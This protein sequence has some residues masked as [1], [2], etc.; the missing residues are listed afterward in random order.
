MRRLLSAALAGLLLAIAAPAVGETRKVAVKDNKFAPVARSAAP[1][2]VIRFKWN[3]A[4]PHDVKF[5]KA[6]RGAKPRK[7]GLRTTG[8]CRRKVAKAG[9][10]KYVCTIHLQSDNMRGRI[11]VD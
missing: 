7:C 11:V 9:V 10:Y 8:K 1:G 5:T 3:G 4:N 6:P 2:D